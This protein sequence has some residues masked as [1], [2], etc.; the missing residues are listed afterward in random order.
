MIAGDDELAAEAD[1][2]S[3]QVE[4]P[5]LADAF[6]HSL[7]QGFAGELLD[8]LDDRPVVIHRDCLGGAEAAGEIE[9][10]RP[11]RDGDHPSA[12]IA[13][14]PGQHRAKEADPDDRYRLTRADVAAAEDVERAAERFAGE[15]PAVELGRELH[16][17]VRPGEIVFGKAAVRQ[18]RHPIA[19]LQG[20]YAGPDRIDNAP[21]F[22]TEAA[23]L[24][25]IFDPRQPG[26]GFE[27]GGANAA[28]FKTDADFP[29]AG[30][31]HLYLLDTDFTRGR[32]HRRSHAHSLSFALFSSSAS[33]TSPASTSRSISWSSS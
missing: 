28:A 33:S 25:R 8:L 23:R 20:V 4:R 1:Q 14:Q 6:D 29:F 7:A 3:G 13:G 22:V 12:G 19:C 16:D 5:L 18:R 24:A 17:H 26:P 2:L 21:A 11:A 27:V 10:L 15:G 32:Q 31:G 30:L 9:R